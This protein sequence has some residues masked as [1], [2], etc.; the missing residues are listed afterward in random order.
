M[1]VAEV[2]VTCLY[3]TESCLSWPQGETPLLTAIFSLPLVNMTETECEL[4]V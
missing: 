4:R 1:I 3:V 2:S